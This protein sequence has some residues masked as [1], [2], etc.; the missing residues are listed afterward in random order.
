MEKKVFVKW[1]KKKEKNLR[2]S[3]NDL[4]EVIHSVELFLSLGE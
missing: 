4:S 2:V 1:E 3:E